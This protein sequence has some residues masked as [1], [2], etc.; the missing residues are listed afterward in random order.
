SREVRAHAAA[1]DEESERAEDQE[2][3]NV[4]RGPSHADCAALLGNAVSV[5]IFLAAA[6][7][8]KPVSWRGLRADWGGTIRWINGANSCLVVRRER[9]KTDLARRVLSV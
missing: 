9:T 8:R 2:R 1:A 4:R 6:V 3:R 5:E 7:A